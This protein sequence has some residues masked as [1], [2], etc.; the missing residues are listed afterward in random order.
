M[1]LRAGELYL[2]PV[3]YE[4]KSDIMGMECGHML[5][6]DCYKEYLIS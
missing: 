6:R 3:C 1:K 4:E 2:C 5:C